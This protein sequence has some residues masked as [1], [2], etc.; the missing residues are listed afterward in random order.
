MVYSSS[1]L[2]AEVRFDYEHYH[3]LV[4]QMLAAGLGFV[5]LTVL[6]QQDYRKLCSARVA[7]ACLG[8]VVFLLIVAYT[9]G[10][11][12]RW[13]PLGF[14]NLQPSEFAKPAL[15]VFLAWFVTLRAPPSTA[16]TVRPAGL[17][18]IGLTI[19]VAVA[20]LARAGAGGDR[21]GNLL[22][23]RAQ[24]ALHGD[25]GSGGPGAWHGGGRRQA[26]QLKRVLD[27]LDQGISTWSGSTRAAAQ[28][29]VEAAAR[30]GHRPHASIESLSA[31]R[32]P[33]WA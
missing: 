24:P 26:V 19:A 10:T 22:Y 13:I 25:R 16:T 12:R 31:R 2:I 1:T 14:L 9:V 5:T 27:F 7:F 3:F 23:R 6:S 11:R 20:D 4:R 15:I 8:I 21:G 28:T 18:L 30:S 32:V 29:W 33:A 17:A